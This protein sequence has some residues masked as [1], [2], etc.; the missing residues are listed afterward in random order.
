MREDM[1]KVIVERPRTGK[2][3]RPI[4]LRLRND[5]DG[6]TRLGM[7]AYYGHLD[8]NENL[9]PLR[10]YLRAQIGRPWNKVFS[11]I[12]TGIDRRNTVQE[13]IHQHVGDFIAI[14]VQ[15]KDGKVIALSGAGPRELW[16]EEL[17]V[18][19]RTGIIREH[20]H[21]RRALGAA[22]WRKQRAEEIAARRRV[23]DE[24]TLLLRIDGSW[25]RVEIAPLPDALTCRQGQIPFDAVLKRPLVHPHQ[26]AA[27]LQHWYGSASVYGVSKRQAG[28]RELSLH[29]IV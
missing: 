24:R 25:Y 12:C 7:R 9:K 28:K 17:Y 26:E 6:P 4:A 2:R 10:R 29:G 16:H 13:H 1:Y 20:R 27:R 14:N 21:G 22:D 19:P 23:V 5:L 15:E 3:T 8:L 11:E 18:D